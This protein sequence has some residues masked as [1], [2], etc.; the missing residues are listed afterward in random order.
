MGLRSRGYRLGLAGITLFVAR[1]VVEYPSRYAMSKKFLAFT[2]IMLEL[3]RF[4]EGQGLVERVR[5]QLR[6]VAEQ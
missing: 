1:V 6:C 3:G 2:T 4:F 5:D